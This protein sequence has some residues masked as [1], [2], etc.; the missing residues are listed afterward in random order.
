MIA[1]SKTTLVNF[2]A[3]QPFFLPSFPQGEL[4]NRGLET[5][6]KMIPRLGFG[7]VFDTAAVSKVAV[8]KMQKVT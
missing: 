5:R 7:L 8:E 2:L 4:A 3:F 6:I 1:T